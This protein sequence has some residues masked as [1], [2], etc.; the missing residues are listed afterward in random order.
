MFTKR[1]LQS[2]Q[3]LR[4]KEVAIGFTET[5]LSQQAVRILPKSKVKLIRIF[6]KQI[7]LLWV[8]DTG[9]CSSC[10][11]SPALQLPGHG[12]VAQEHDAISLYCCCFLD[13]NT[14]PCSNDAQTMSWL[15]NQ[16]DLWNILQKS[17]IRT[18]LLALFLVRVFCFTQSVFLPIWNP[19]SKAV[20]M[21]LRD[22]LAGMISSL[23]ICLLWLP[24]STIISLSEYINPWMWKYEREKM[25]IRKN[26]LCHCF[27]PPATCIVVSSLLEICQCSFIKL[28]GTLEQQLTVTNFF[29]SSL[30]IWRLEGSPF[31]FVWTLSCLWEIF[32]LLLSPDLFRDCTYSQPLLS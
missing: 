1:E 6:Q 30:N 4:L 32:F 21:L 19:F 31:E 17:L 2:P 23:V 28:A 5:L 18:W 22:G 24:L 29:L 25:R 7:Q 3:I 14:F 10:V 26:Y 20:F 15:C 27:Q 16:S 13:A 8:D 9:L 12:L 11:L